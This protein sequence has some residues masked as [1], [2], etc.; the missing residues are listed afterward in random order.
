[1]MGRVPPGS[2]RSQSVVIPCRCFERLG[3]STH[4]LY[5]WMERVND[6]GKVYRSRTAMR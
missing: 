3:V 6:N 1:M 5:G 2:N 4:S